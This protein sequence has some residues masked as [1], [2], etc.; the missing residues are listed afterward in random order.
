MFLGY[1]HYFRAI[2]I[3]FIVAGHTIDA[4][5]W[6]AGSDIERVLRIL[7]SNGSTLFVFIAGYLFQ[8]LTT[9]YSTKKYYLSKLKNVIVPY[10][11]ISIPAIVIFVAIMV[12]ETAWQGFYDNPEWLQVILF[13]VTGIHL[14]PLWFVPM[15]TLFYL[16]APLLVKGD[17]SGKLYWLIPLAIVTSCF[18]ARGLPHQS[19]IHFFSVYI[20]GMYA[21]RYKEALNPILGQ[22]KTILLF[23]ALV[24]LFAFV[25]FSTTDATMTY[26]NYL[27]KTSMCFFFIGL[28]F[29]VNDK[30]TSKFVSNIADTSFGVFFIHSYVLTGMKMGYDKLSGG[31]V[32]G[33]ILSYSVMAIFVLLLCVFIINAIQKVFGKKSRYLV[34]S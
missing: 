15:I 24:C 18:V 17:K 8:H 10:L 2:A 9:K 12:R 3:F 27:Q 14:A 26:W 11:L 5:A 4:F 29:K 7:I 31:K 1:I 20:L 21:S 13:Y 22:T 30:L 28:L 19:F 32:S 25:E 33:D 34:G 16:V 6:P 23:G